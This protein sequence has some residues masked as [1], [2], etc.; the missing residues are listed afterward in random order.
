MSRPHEKPKSS[1][2]IL[3]STQAGKT[4][5]IEHIK[6]YANPEY[7]INESLLGNGMASK[8]DT[9]TPF[10]VESNLPTYEAYRKDTG[11]IFDLK[12]LAHQYEDQEDYQDILL[13]D[14]D[15]VGMRL[16]SQDPN[17]ISESME[18][19]FL[20][21]PGLNGTQGRDSEH[22]ASIVNEIISTR[23]F[24]LIV[25]VI[26]SKV[27]LTEDRQLALEYFAYVLHGLF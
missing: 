25:F 6:R 10:L 12:N 4:A 27:P 21:T 7:K 13:A 14:A 18:F 24:N 11:E 19:R 15:A 8:T 26:S 3:G 5:L 17:T 9:T 1:V 20:D 2:L 23:S 16:V 22:A